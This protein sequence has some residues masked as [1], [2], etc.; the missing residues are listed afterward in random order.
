MHINI[1]IYKQIIV[2]IKTIHVN[3]YC[4]FFLGVIPKLINRDKLI[5]INT[6]AEI[7]RSL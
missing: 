6:R 5:Y 4:G 2:Y 3:Y 1:N 7:Q